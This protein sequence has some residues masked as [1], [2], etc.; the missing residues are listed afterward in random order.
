MP[1]DEIEN[2]LTYLKLTQELEGEKQ[3]IELSLLPEDL[4]IIIDAVEI[5]KET[6]IGPEVI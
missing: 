3:R 2:L 4:E 5:Y 1:L 6:S